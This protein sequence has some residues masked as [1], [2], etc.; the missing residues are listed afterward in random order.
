MNLNCKVYG[1]ENTEVLIILH[2]LFGM[3]DNW[4]TLAKKFAQ[5]HKVFTVDLRNHGKSAHTAEMSYRHMATDLKEFME[6]KGIYT[7]NIIGHSMGGKA[8]MAFT[9][10]F[11]EH[12][13]RMIVVDIAPKAYEPKHNEIIDALTSLPVHELKTREEADNWLSERI[14]QASIRLFLLKNLSRT[15]DGFEWKMNL[16]VI[17]EN[18]QEIIGGVDIENGFERPVLMIYGADSNYLNEDDIEQLE[19]NYDN[20]RF[21]KIEKAGHWV[22][23]EQPVA[24]FESVNEFL[25]C[26]LY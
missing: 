1:E 14:K 3:L 9:N 7:A 26:P 19:L 22:H 10:M 8:V 18:Y 25:S 17:I 6:E 11:P 23:A 12:V 13:E 20:V 5:A 24:F 16:P 4:S 2:G 21:K 15:K